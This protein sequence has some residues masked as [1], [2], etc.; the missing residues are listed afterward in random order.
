MDS[1]EIRKNLRE[2]LKKLGVK[3]QEIWNKEGNHSFE[4]P[5]LTDVEITVDELSIFIQKDDKGFSIG[6]EDL[7]KAAY[8]NASFGGIPRLDRKK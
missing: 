4:E 6:V 5:D 1:Y 8:S 7:I 2:G 3:E